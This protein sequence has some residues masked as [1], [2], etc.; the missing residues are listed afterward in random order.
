MIR[1]L[2]VFTTLLT[3]LQIFQQL[4]STVCLNAVSYTHLSV[5]TLRYRDSQDG[6]SKTFSIVPKSLGATDEDL[7]L[8]H[9]SLKFMRL[10]EEGLYEL[11]I[12]Y[13]SNIYKMCIRDRF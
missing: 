4:G 7:S 2:P 5:A 12:E 8:I 10:I 3:R 9:I 11:R 13:Q 1:I 6:I